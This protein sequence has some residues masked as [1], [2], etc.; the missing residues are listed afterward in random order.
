MPNYKS[1]GVGITHCNYRIMMDERDGWSTHTPIYY[2]IKLKGN[3]KPIQVVE[4]I[5]AIY[6]YLLFESFNNKL[7]LSN[8]I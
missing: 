5:C 4:F 1:V 7:K 3:T 6:Y 2:F 8:T